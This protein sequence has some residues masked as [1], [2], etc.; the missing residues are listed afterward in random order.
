MY[1]QVPP[2]PVRC[3]DCGVLEDNRK[4]D[5]PSLP[6]GYCGMEALVECDAMLV[7]QVA[8]MYSSIHPECDRMVADYLSD[9]EMG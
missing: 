6:C 1:Q 2:P 3:D 7:H 9:Q 4:L 5:D 8:P